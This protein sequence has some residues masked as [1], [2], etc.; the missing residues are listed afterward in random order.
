MYENKFV[1]SKMISDGENN[2]MEN[3]YNKWMKYRKVL[4]KH[5]NAN[6]ERIAWINFQELGAL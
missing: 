4:P 3:K 2:F 1:I 5:K 6:T